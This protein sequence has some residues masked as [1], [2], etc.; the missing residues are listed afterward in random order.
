MIQK[1]IGIV[2]NMLRNLQ[3]SYRTIRTIKIS[4]LLNLK[5]GESR[6][7]VLH[8]TSSVDKVT[9]EYTK[10]IHFTFRSKG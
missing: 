3:N 2:S 10:T 6:L 9:G 7:T 5:K 1:K 8:L 4:K